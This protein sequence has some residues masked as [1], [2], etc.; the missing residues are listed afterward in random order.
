[1]TND[2]SIGQAFDNYDRSRYDR[3]IKATMDL[4]EKSSAD[5]FD[6]SEIRVTMEIASDM[7]LEKKM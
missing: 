3:L 1:M 2:I 5:K 6:I 7:I 4:L